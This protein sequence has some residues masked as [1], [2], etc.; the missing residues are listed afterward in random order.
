MLL[1]RYIQKQS[2]LLNQSVVSMFKVK[3]RKCSLLIMLNV[4]IKMFYYREK[5][6][7]LRFVD[8][9]ST[10]ASRITVLAVFHVWQHLFW[11]RNKTAASIWNI[12]A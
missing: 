11:S 5:K 1:T 3:G 12:M 6:W 9:H 7:K 2:A 4:T 8:P 10:D